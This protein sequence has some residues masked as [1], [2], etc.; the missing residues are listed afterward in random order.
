M[1][2]DENEYTK[3]YD[4]WIYSKAGETARLECVNVDCKHKVYDTEENRTMLN[5]NGEYVETINPK[6]K[7]GIQSYHWP[8]WSMRNQ[9][10][11]EVVERYLEAK[12]SAKFKDR[13][14]IEDFW[15]KDLAEFYTPVRDMDNIKIVSEDYDSKEKYGDFTFLTVD[16]QQDLVQLFWVVR[17]WCAN[18][19]SRQ[20]AR[21]VATS[22]TEITEIQR[23]YGILHNRVGVDSGYRATTIYKEC[24]KNCGQYNSKGKKVNLYWNAFKGFD[25]REFLHTDGVK[26]LYGALAQ[27]DPI[28]AAYKGSSLLCICGVTTHIKTCYIH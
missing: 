17:S 6:G 20:I 10:F 19:D 22:F 18:G 21:G 26:R 14:K 13:V 11:G 9:K 4:Q 25:K 23:K 8:C 16:C 15:K 1:W 12:Q 7:K 28:D 2:C 27:G 24:I 3:P 5:L